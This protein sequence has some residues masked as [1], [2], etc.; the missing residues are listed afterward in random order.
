MAGAPQTASAQEQ[1]TEMSSRSFAQSANPCSFSD[2]PEMS[3]EM[4]VEIVRGM[5]VA[6]KLW[7]HLFRE[8][9]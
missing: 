2:I 3:L 5:N 7:F 8:D 4:G 9:N 1:Q 6:D